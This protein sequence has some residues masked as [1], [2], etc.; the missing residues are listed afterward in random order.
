[1]DA[2]KI[3]THAMR[4]VVDSQPAKLEDCTPADDMAMDVITCCKEQVRAEQWAKELR[5]A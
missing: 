4:Y 5:N 2:I 1:M 3:L